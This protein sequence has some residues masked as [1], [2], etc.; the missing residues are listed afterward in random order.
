ML[1]RRYVEHSL[2]SRAAGYFAAKHV[3]GGLRKPLQFNSLKNEADYKYAIHRS[4]DAGAEGSAWPTPSELFTPHYGEAI[5]RSIVARHRRL[6]PDEPLQMV[7]IGAGR[8]TF[9]CDVLRYLEREEPALYAGCRYL[10]VEISANL[11]AEQRARIAL[12]AGSDVVVA[13]GADAASFSSSSSPSSS[14]PRVEVIHKDAMQWA[15]EMGPGALQGP[16][17]FTMLEVLD[18]LGHDQLRVTAEADGSTRC[19]ELFVTEHDAEAYLQQEAHMREETFTPQVAWSEDTF[20]GQGGGRG[21]IWRPSYRPLEDRTLSEVCELLHLTD[22]DH[23]DDL[24][25]EIATADGAPAAASLAYHA[26]SLLGGLL[27]GGGG[28]APGQSIEMCVPTSCWRLLRALCAAAPEHQFTIADFSW[29]PPQPNGVIN[30][31]VVQMQKAGATI[32]LH[33]EYLRATGEVDILFPTNFDHLAHLIHAASAMSNGGSSGDGG[34]EAKAIQNV[35]TAEFMR[36]WHDLEAT[37]TQDGFNPLVDDF[38]NTRFV[39]TG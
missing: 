32:D 12:S 16:W 10:V 31:P 33:G 5:A 11:A 27:G 23:L 37:R 13:E 38:T 3:V 34:G 14:A 19:E 9:T 20:K 24:R 29:L 22:M 15:E 17:W 6:Y 18:N 8:G 30:A 25:G 4:W 2:Y 28:R 39:V 35:T 7:E 1:L 21:S 26:Q 36:E